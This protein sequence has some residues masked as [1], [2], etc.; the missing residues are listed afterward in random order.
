MDDRVKKTRVGL[1][2]ISTPIFA[3][4]LIMLF[5]DPT[6]FAQGT[7]TVFVRFKEA[8]GVSEGTPVRKNGILIGRVAETEFAADNN[9]V[10]VTL[11]IQDNRKLNQNEVCTIKGGLLGDAVIEFVTPSGQIAAGK[12]ISPGDYVDGSVVGSPLE[13]FANLEGDLTA[14]AASVTDAGHQISRLAQ[15]INQTL[16]TD[17]KQV[18]RILDKMEVSLD[19]FRRTTDNINGLVGDDE[20]Q[21]ELRRTIVEM[22]KLFQQSRETLDRMQDTIESANR[23]MRNLEGLTEPLGRKGDQLVGNIDSTVSKLDELL[24]QFV[25][26]GKQL[27]DENGSLG[28]LV[29][30]PELYQN[31][32]K[33]ARNVEKLTTELR[34]IVRDVRVFSDKIARHPETLGVRGALHKNSGIK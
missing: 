12:L 2:V 25:L 27:N 26:F 11:K 1:V 8:P 17:D 4:I 5:G 32:N 13:S 22:P 10:I 9:G 3:L 18:Q 16:D 29:R 33:A 15:S 30:D 6:S 20:V 21:Q 23:N 34:P 31:L 28:M 19:S 7:Y 14:A 24:A